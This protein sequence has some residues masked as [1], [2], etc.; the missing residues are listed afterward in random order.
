MKRPFGLLAACV[1]VIVTAWWWLG[2]PVTMPPAGPGDDGKLQCVSYAP[3]RAN[4][5]PLDDST[6]VDA[7]DIEADLV[8]LKAITNCVRTY[9][10]DHGDDQVAGIAQ[11]LGMKV[12]Q[13]LWVSSDPAR[14]RVQVDAAVAL[15][16]RYPDTVTSVVVGNEVLLRGEMSASDLAAIIRDVK[17][18]VPCPVTYADVWEFWNRNP[19]LAGAVD[20]VTV[21][22]LPYWEDF[23]I[24]ADKAAAHVEAVRRQMVERFPGKEVMI[25]EVGWPSAGRM[26]EGA[27]PSPANQARFLQQVTA[28]ART[29][30]YRANVIEAFD[31]PWKRALEGTVGGYWGVFDAYRRAPKFAWGA[32]VSNHPAWRSQAAGGAALAILVFAAAGTLARRR[33]IAVPPNRWFG[34][35]VIAAVSGFLIG[36][37]WTNIA[38]VSLGVGGWM[39][40]IAWGAVALLAPVAAGASLAVDVPAPSFGDILGPREK[41]PCAPVALVAGATRLVLTVL[42]LQIALMLVFDPRYVDFPFAP[43]LGAAVPFLVLSQ[44]RSAVTG[45]RPAAE[46]LA[47]AILAGAAVYIV[48]NET[49]ANWQAVMMCAGLVMLAFTLA[50]VRVAPG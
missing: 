37:A 21:H 18:A 11:K 46:K 26:R 4:Q 24:P 5:N 29:G 28:D 15:A 39:E 47:A 43:L 36:L 40:G 50:R 7:K 32:P 10:T 35:A 48:I 41:R 16:K 13:G 49:L 25:G 22:M 14:T 12:M 31:Q 1:A 17:A 23:P 8:S 34:V 27:L 45:M 30:H 44:A 3:Y 20:F 33:G 42:S 2:R 19:Q 38:I 9:S 6:R